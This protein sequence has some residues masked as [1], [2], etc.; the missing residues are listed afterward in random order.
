MTA[1][2]MTAQWGREAERMRDQ[3]TPGAERGGATGGVRWE[4]LGRGGARMNEEG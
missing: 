4:E 2:L 3:S 1:I